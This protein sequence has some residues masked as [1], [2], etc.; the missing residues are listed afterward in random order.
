[1]TD[2]SRE[3]VSRREFLKYA[4]TVSAAVALSEVG[5]GQSLVPPL[6]QGEGEEPPEPAPT[7]VSVALGDDLDEITRGALAAIGGIETVVDPGDV[8]FIKP[9]AVSWG[10]GTIEDNVIVSGERTKPEIVMAVADECLRAGASRVILGEGGQSTRFTYPEAYYMDGSV[11]VKDAIAALNEEYGPK[12]SFVQTNSPAYPWFFVPSRTNL[13]QVAVSG[14]VMDADKV[15]TIPVLKTHHSCAVTI[16]MKN[17]VGVTPTG[18]Y[19]SWR[20]KLHLCDL[21][22]DQIIVDINRGIAPDLSFVDASIGAEG[23]A[24]SVGPDEGISVDMRDRVGSWAVLAGRD[25][26]AVDCTATRMIGHEP[27]WVH[28]LRWAYQQGLGELREEEIDLVGA[29][30]EEI[31][32]DWIPSSQSGYPQKEEGH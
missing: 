26:V 23:N 19:G 30:M 1:M 13:G 6:T 25:V 31:R 10:T 21:G 7:R 17:F 8:V 22:M 4:L 28:H 32:M 27:L 12:V 14:P 20:Y 5:L 15:I 9:N 11:K 3:P 2:G 24:P 29:Q 16:A 18:L